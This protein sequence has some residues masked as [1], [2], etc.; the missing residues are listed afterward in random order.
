MLELK[1]M[2]ARQGSRTFTP[3]PSSSK[4][5]PTMHAQQA[6]PPARKT[7]PLT[8]RLS[9]S[10]ICAGS[11]RA[12]ETSSRLMSSGC[13]NSQTHQDQSHTHPRYSCH[14]RSKQETRFNCIPL[15]RSAARLLRAPRDALST[16]LPIGP[17][18]TLHPPGTPQMIPNG[19]TLL[20]TSG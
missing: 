15:S 6:A 14:Q 8:V 19:P 11:Y 20:Q 7:A 3:P 10:D 5:K 1:L 17:A 13:S 18:K 12:L 16:S 9:N 2:G 4:P